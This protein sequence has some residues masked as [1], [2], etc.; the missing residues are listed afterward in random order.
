MA[1][2]SLT[3]TWSG[4]ANPSYTT[5]ELNASSSPSFAAG[6][7]TSFAASVSSSPAGLSPNTSYYFR[8]RG[9][10]LDNVLTSYFT[11]LTTATHA[12]VPSNPA[13]TSIFV[14]SG[15]LTWSA[16]GNPSDTVYVVQV[17]SDNFFSLTDSSTTLATSATFFTLNPGTVNFLRVKAINR[18]GVSSSFSTV[19]STT[20]GNLSNTTPP[21]APGTPTPDRSFSYD[22]VAMFSWADATSSVGILDYN[23]IIGTLPGGSDLF[24][25]TVSV[26]S[27]TATGMQT[28]K[29]YYAQV[30]ARSN[31]GVYSV[32]SGVSAGLPVFIPAQNAEISKPFSWPNPFDPRTGE[33]QIGFNMKETGEVVLKV[34]TL[35]GRL[36]RTA[37]RSYAAGNQVLTWDGKADSGQRVSPGGYV[38][39]IEKHYGS[40]TSTQK[41]K[42]AVV[43]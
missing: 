35:Q 38:A 39:V 40:G 2:N 11:T 7:S 13:A 24:S 31:A 4:G 6:V 15:A 42:I 1:A 19:V 32:F 26:A 36:L 43:Y 21:A 37:S 10:N 8:A 29:S 9:R 18:S 16:N 33:A 23:L 41:L 14:T 27:Y 12:A 28:G 30:R 22:G 34:Y 5:Y 17:S 3:L 20:S 25:G